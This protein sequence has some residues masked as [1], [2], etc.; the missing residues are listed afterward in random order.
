MGKISRIR[1]ISFIGSGNVATHLAI[2]FKRAGLNI[3]EVYSPYKLHAEQF[4]QKIHCKSVTSPSALDTDVDLIIIAVPDAKIGETINNLPESNAIIAHT[5]GFSSMNVLSSFR[6]FGVFYP[7]QTFTKDIEIDLGDVPFFIEANSDLTRKELFNLALKLSKNVNYIS[8]ADRRYLHVA[9][10][11]VNNFTNHIYHVASEFL[12]KKGIEFKFLQPLIM[13]TARK[14]RIIDP[15]AAQTGPA[16][17]NDQVTIAE[18]EEMLS[19]LPEYKE[20]YQLVSKQISKK[21]H[22]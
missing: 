13:E 22:G 14:I 19:D 17:R 11:M 7:L 1:K 8:S 10:V 15:E 12:E 2:A 9:A 3:I 18:H 20:L 16:K 5:S 21:Y 6:H 4:A